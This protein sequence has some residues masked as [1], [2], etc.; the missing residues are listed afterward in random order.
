MN[1]AIFS[2]LA[3]AGLCDAIGR[4][5]YLFQRLTGVFGGRFYRFEHILSW[6]SGKVV[7]QSNPKKPAAMWRDRTIV[8]AGLAVS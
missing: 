8:G 7:G 2:L 4:Y 1:P 3:G 6:S 5:V